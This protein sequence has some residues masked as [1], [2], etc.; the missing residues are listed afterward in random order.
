MTPINLF[1]LAALGASLPMTLL[2]QCRPPASSHEARLLAFYEAPIAFSMAVAPERLASGAVRLGGEAIPVPSPD[3]ALQHPEYCYA[4][5]RNNTKLAPVFGRPRIAVGLPDGFAIEASYLPDVRVGDAE[6]SVVSGALSRTQRVPFT[7]GL[8]TSMLR[9]D[10]TTG[11][12]RGAITC[13]RSS[14][15]IKDVNVPCY[16]SEPSQDTFTPNS[17]GAEGALGVDAWASRV[18]LYVGGGV[19]WLRPRFQA[20]FTDGFGNVDRTTVSVNLVRGAAFTGI[21]WRVRGPFTLSAQLYAVPADV[22]TT[23]VA[24]QL[25]LP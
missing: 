10:G 21:T 13:P 12:V 8:V 2:A 23:R 25:A 20:G 11:R 1:M 5:T 22:T 7:R 9:V 16:G 24:A 15:Q 19:R 14:L 18:G 3:P 6:A 4:N 17:L